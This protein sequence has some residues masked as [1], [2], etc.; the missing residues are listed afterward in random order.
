MK[1][2]SILMILLLVLLLS[3]C[4]FQKRLYNFGYHVE[5]IYSKKDEK[6]HEKSIVNES[7]SFTKI[8]SETKSEDL[9]VN[10]NIEHDF[11]ALNENNN[12]NNQVI[13]LT[14]NENELPSTKITSNNV[15]SGNYKAYKVNFKNQQKINKG[16]S[17]LS[18]NNE[19]SMFAIAGF[20]SSIVG[21][22][23]LFIFGFPFL[24]GTTS[25]VLSAIGLNETTTKNMKGKGFAIAGLV[26]GILTVVLW[27]LFILAIIAAFG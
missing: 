11:I 15:K 26:I 19:F 17:N 7:K 14:K 20:I 24:M 10:S 23:A 22:L 8:K 21:L 18:D 25:I 27:W 16:D 3:S 9:N 12:K 13:L 4:T 5:S 2:H 1:K 6:Y